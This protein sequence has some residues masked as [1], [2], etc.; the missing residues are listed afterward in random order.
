MRI[1]LLLLFVI[2]T[3]PAALA[4]QERSIHVRVHSV[5]Q[6]LPFVTIQLLGADSTV[7][8]STTCDSLGQAVIRVSNPS[9]AWIRTSMPGYTQV[10][11][12]LAGPGAAASMTIDIDLQPELHTI[13]EVTVRGKKPLLQFLPD[14]TVVNVDAGISNA[15]TTVME[16]LEKSPGVIV[17]REGSISLRGRTGVVVMIDG[18]LTQL[19]GTDLQNLLNG[20]SASQVETIEL[21]NNPS[22][23]YDAA[24]NAGL[25]NI[26]LKKNKQ[27]GFNAVLGLSYGQ[28]KLPKTNN[29]LTLNYRKAALSYFLNYN[30]SSNRNF[31]RL[32]AD[33]SYF[34]GNGTK[35]SSLEQDSDLR[36]RGLSHTLRG[37]VD[38]SF[39]KRTGIGLAG[40]YFYL[41]RRNRG[42]NS[43]DWKNNTGGTDSTI[44]TDS[45]SSSQIKQASGNFNFRHQFSS[46]LE[47]TADLDLVKYQLF[48]DQY[49]ENRSSDPQVPLDAS[50][51][52]IPSDLSI[53]S[54]KTDFVRRLAWGSVETGLKSSRV[55]TDNLAGYELL[56]QGE[57]K[58]DNGKSNHFI[59]TENIHAAYLDVSAKTG[60]FELQGGL[61]YENTRY[62]GSQ[63][64]NTVT[65]DS[66]FSRKY[67]NLFPT[68]MARYQADSANSFTLRAGRRIDRPAFQK[69]NPFV[70]ILNKYTYQQGNPYFN[71]QFTWNME[72]THTYRGILNTTLS[73]N[74]TSDYFSQIFYSDEI[75]GIIIYSEG[76]IGNMNNLGLSVSTQ[77]NIAPW[78]SLSLQADLNHKRLR[79]QLWKDYRA[80]IT[81][82]NF[83]VNNQFRLARGW[84]AELSGFYTT[85][86]QNDLQEVLDPNGSVSVGVAKQLLRDKATL[87]LALRDIF[88]TQRMQG[89]THFRSVEEFFKL[90]RDTRVAT[91][92]F[93]WRLGRNGKPAF[94]KT[95][96][97]SD[98]MERVGNIN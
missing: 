73:Y 93:T 13:G 31:T 39:S 61:R 16:V 47:W 67:S 26:R 36:S 23:K 30:W 74:I 98:V 71:P 17:D 60:R 65:T 6:P 5:N 51:G 72:L 56:D 97:A 63:L 77:L 40:S 15:G 12:P 33:R 53:Y 59:Y 78:W 25:I 44:I 41:Q 24:G 68:A 70:I 87:R 84:S 7:I 86:S 90:T 48:S 45:R 42:D 75:T 11:S 94:R 83:N 62:N 55:E 46:S 96:G 80:E 2:F 34:A 20:M 14:R 43:A 69:L 88:Y 19:A 52:R 85:R 37:G 91:L 29:N 38:Y 81:Q 76:N 4:Q 82:G 35:E 49:F 10:T 64:G 32:Y 54:A 28:G 22:S 8:G 95:G 89:L 79:G 18:K 58:P 92:S 66:S 21:I 1:P 9:A 27:G 3:F 57:W 50:S